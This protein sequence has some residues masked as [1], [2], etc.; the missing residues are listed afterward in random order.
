MST[1]KRLLLPSTATLTGSLTWAR[2][3]KPAVSGI[4]RG[5]GAEDRCDVASAAGGGGEDGIDAIRGGVGDVE[6]A[7]CIDR[8]RRGS[9]QCG[10]GRLARNG[11]G[12]GAV[13]CD[14]MENAGLVEGVDEVASGV[15]DVEDAVKVEAEA[16]G[17]DEAGGEDAARSG[18]VDLD[19][20]VGCASLGD[21]EIVEAVGVDRSWCVEAGDVAGVDGSIS[22]EAGDGAVGCVG[23]EEV[24]GWSRLPGLRE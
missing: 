2:L 7:R 21:E 8:E 3:A 15:C 19:D 6:I 5:A 14:L 20:V 18:G 4:A 24:S 16:A 10:S 9:E 1:T 17:R 13:A 23:D 12:R 22:A 11:G